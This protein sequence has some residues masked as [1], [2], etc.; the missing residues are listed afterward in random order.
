MLEEKIAEQKK[1]GKAVRVILLKARQEGGTTDVA[2]M[3]FHDTIRLNRKSVIISHEPDSTSSIFDIYKTYYENLPPMMRPMKR[4]DNKKALVF[5]NP[6]DKTR[7]VNPGLGSSIGIFTAGRKRGGRGQTIHNLHCSEIAYWDANARD[8]MDGLLQAVPDHK[9]TMVIMESTANGTSGYFHDEYWRAKNGESDYLAVFLPWW[10]HEEY[11]IKESIRN[12]DDYE[13]DL[14]DILKKHYSASQSLYKLAWRRWAIRNKCGG[15]IKKFMQEYPATDIEA[16]QKKSGLVYP[17]FDER[18]HV[19][20][21]YNPDPN[22]YVFIGGYDFGAVHPTAYVIF[23]VDKDGIVYQFAEFKRV[24]TTFEEQA[25]A[26]KEM[27]YSLHISRRYRGHDSGAVQAE[28][29]LK[30][31]GVRLA[32]GIV[33]REAGIT[34]L[35]G[36]LRS[37]KYVVSD[38]C[39]NTIYEFKNHVHKTDAE[40]Q[41]K[42]GVVRTDGDPTKDADVLKKDDDCLDALRYGI[43]TYLK[44]RPK[45]A[46]DAK[47][48]L[49]NKVKKELRLKHQGKQIN[50]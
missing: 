36:L 10:I 15:D 9:E 19:V 44:L 45:P 3:I 7:P 2:G 39:V 47:E 8:L 49:V 42:D 34:T 14:F 50:W 11:E 40:L 37:G 31:Y 6:D 23:G 1:S 12:L 16:F 25:K 5:E 17:E 29:E 33:H 27:E 18:L 28:V 43:T 46:M 41:I 24:G 20:S 21:H 32:E 30:K 22:E 13:R 48:K 26:I 38:R 35:R 4:Y